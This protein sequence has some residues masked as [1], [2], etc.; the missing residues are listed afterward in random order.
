MKPN[1]QILGEVLEL[2]IAAIVPSYMNDK[3]YAPINQADP[4]IRALAQSIRE[5]GLKEPLVITT[6]NVIL[7]G[8]R[9]YTACKLAGLQQVRCRRESISSKDKGFIR[10]LREYNRQRVKTFDMV[11]R[12]GVLDADPEEAYSALVE[13]RKLQSA[14]DAEVIKIEGK[15]KRAAISFAKEPF[16]EAILRVLEANRQ[17]W[18]VTD[19]YIHYQLLNDPPLTHANKRDSR[20]RNDIR[21]YKMTCDLVTRAR[22]AGKIPFHVI[23]DPTR[24]VQRWEVWQGPAAFVKD[25][26]DDFM[27]GYWRDLQQSQS[28]HI[29][30]IGEK[31]TIEGVIRPVAEEFCIPLTIGR[32]YC[33]LPPRHEMARRFKR[34]GREKLVLLVLSDFDPEGEDIAH[35]FA[36]SMRDDFGVR[37]VQAVKVALTADQVEEMQLPPQ[38][39]AKA[40]SSRRKRFTKKY[41]DDV[42][43]LEAVPALE[44]QRLL[45]EAIDAVLDPVAFNAELDAEKK[46]AANLAALRA[47][48]G[49]VLRDSTR[50][51]EQ[52]DENGGDLGRAGGRELGCEEE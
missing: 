34:S 49:E 10:L 30:I 43:E 23:H 37:T 51:G 52:M 45:R 27:K 14:I 5:H 6:D 41:G 18:P 32:G 4:E 9:R 19:R 50:W 35:S 44:L 8:H 20:Y 21:S 47:A 31:N 26:V 39:K 7:S 29:E 48:V 38:M 24:Q 17:F 2:P 46:D 22:L 3:L 36:R 40:G 28:N 11:V 33:S 15:K 13:H 42:F 25:Q 16:L 1:N 12:E